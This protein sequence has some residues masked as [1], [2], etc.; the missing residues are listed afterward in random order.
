MERITGRI[1]DPAKLREWVEAR[2][3]TR[4]AYKRAILEGTHRAETVLLREDKMVEIRSCERLPGQ[5]LEDFS[6]QA[7]SLNPG[8]VVV[9]HG[10]THPLAFILPNGHFHSVFEE[11]HG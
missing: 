10:Q 8:G 4:A 1:G 3:Y 6:R 11:R 5:S 2:G 7:K 9:L